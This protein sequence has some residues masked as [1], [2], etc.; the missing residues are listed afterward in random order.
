MLLCVLAGCGIENLVRGQDPEFQDPVVVVET[1]EQAP[2]QKVD[3]LFVVD[4]TGSMAEEQAA[5]AES[6]AAFVG[7]ID[8]LGL[9]Y[10]IGVVTTASESDE[11]GILQGDPWIITAASQDPVGDLAQAVDVGTD[12]VDEAGLGAMVLALSTPL[13]DD[14]NRGFRRADAALHVVVLSDDDDASEDNDSND[15]SDKRFPQ[16]VPFFVFGPGHT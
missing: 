16:R 6:F 3:L 13:V 15:N 7:A 11:A 1:F 4:D 9:A 5:L 12:G 8:E 2:H 10:H 14:D